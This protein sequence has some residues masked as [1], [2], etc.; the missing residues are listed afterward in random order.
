M[1]FIINSIL[2]LVV[3]VAMDL[4]ARWFNKIVDIGYYGIMEMYTDY[5]VNHQDLKTV[6]FR[7]ETAF[8]LIPLIA[9]LYIAR[10]F[11]KCI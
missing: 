6:L 2:F 5:D 11:R 8:L 7:K 1:A 10:R 4:V 9:T 3:F